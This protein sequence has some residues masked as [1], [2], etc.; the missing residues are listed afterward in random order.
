MYQIDNHRWEKEMKVVIYL[1]CIN[2]YLMLSTLK[3]LKALF[4]L[5]S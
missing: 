4:K 2:F 5:K 1:E 3:K